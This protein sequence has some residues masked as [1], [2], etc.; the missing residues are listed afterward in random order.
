MAKV[1]PGPYPRHLQTCG[2]LMLMYDGSSDPWTSQLTVAASLHL[3][4]GVMFPRWGSLGSA[5]TLPHPAVGDQGLV[6]PCWHRPG[7]RCPAGVGVAPAARPHH[8]YHVHKL[9]GSLIYIG[10][11]L[12]LAMLLL[13]LLWADFCPTWA[14]SATVRPA[15]T[16]HPPLATLLS[17]PSLHTTSGLLQ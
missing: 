12:T 13:L 9:V 10:Y 5:P 14:P 15:D 4:L 2:T 7:C 3:M 11:K 6:K 17:F 16:C 8:A 1:P